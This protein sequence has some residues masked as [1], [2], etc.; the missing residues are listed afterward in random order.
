LEQTRS[1]EEK[2][3]LA[4]ARAALDA[5]ENNDLAAYE[6]AMTDDIEVFTLERARPMRGKE[7]MR[8]YFKA[9][10]KAIGQLD[11]TLDNAWG[12]AQFALVEYDIAGEQ[13]GP[14]AWIPANRD[15]KVVRLHVVDVVELRDGKIARV[16]RCDNPGEIA[17]GF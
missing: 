5:L 10:H 16:W 15:G 12:I 13:I 2:N 6:A 14:L 7:G 3:G 9:M 1:S 4:C 17:A 8:Y 11:T